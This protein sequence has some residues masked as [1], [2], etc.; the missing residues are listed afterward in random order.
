[1]NL[2]NWICCPHRHPGRMKARADVQRER[3]LGASYSYCW[4]VLGDH[5]CGD[6]H[7]QVVGVSEALP[8]VA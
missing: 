4:R 1:M 3:K 2:G 8:A 5:C 6:K 7:R